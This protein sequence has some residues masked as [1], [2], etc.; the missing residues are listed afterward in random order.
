MMEKG[1]CFKWDGISDGANTDLIVTKTVM[2]IMPLFE[3]VI[4]LFGDA[5]GELPGEREK[6]YLDRLNGIMD[7]HNLDLEFS[8]N[9]DDEGADNDGT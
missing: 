4:S 2:N 9:G 5:I 3:D 1:D 6:E 8:L 7:K